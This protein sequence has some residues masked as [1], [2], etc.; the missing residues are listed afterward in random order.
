MPVDVASLGLPTLTSI[1]DS[2]KRNHLLEAAEAFCSFVAFSGNRAA[3]IAYERAEA[4]KGSISEPLMSVRNDVAHIEATLRGLQYFAQDG[5][6]A[7]CFSN[8]SL[9]EHD[10]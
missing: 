10:R 6:L 4:T 5:S 1:A 3:F 8:A 2:V 9:T 7:P